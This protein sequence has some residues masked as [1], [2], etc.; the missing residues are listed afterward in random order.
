MKGKGWKRFRKHLIQIFPLTLNTSELRIDEKFASK[1]ISN[2]FNWR[3][4]AV[5][6]FFLFSLSVGRSISQSDGLL[7]GMISIPVTWHNQH[8][9]LSKKYQ[10]LWETSVISMSFNDTTALV[11][12]SKHELHAIILI[13]A[14]S[15]SLSNMFVCEN[16]CFDEMDKH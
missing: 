4:F 12:T 16:F 10:Y 8:L 1:K 3:M 2:Y 9:D 6:Q 14:W 7:V 11:T 15:S 5:F 13:T